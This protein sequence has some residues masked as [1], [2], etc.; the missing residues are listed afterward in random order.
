MTYTLGNASTSAIN[1]TSTSTGNTITTAGKALGNITFSGAGGSWQNQDDL[2]ATGGTIT[3]TAGEW[4]TGNRSITAVSF[5][6]ANSNVRTFTPGSSNLTFTGTSP[7]WTTSTHTNMTVTANTAT[8]TFTGTSPN[9]LFGSSRDWNGM[10]INL[11]GSG[12]PIINGAG[13]VFSSVTRTGTAVTTDGLFVSGDF[14]VTSGWTLA[15]NSQ[16]NR[17]LVTGNIAGTQRTI[18]NTGATMTWSNVDFEDIG[19]SSAYNAS[20]ITGGCG[21][22]GG[23]SN[24]TFTSP[25]TQTWSGTAS[26]SW[27]GNSWTSRMPLPQDNVVIASAFSPTGRV[28]TVDVPR[29]GASIDFTGT[30]GN[31]ALTFTS[32]ITSNIFGSLT[33]V[34]AMSVANINT[35]IQFAGRGS[36]TLTTAGQLIAPQIVLNA[37][38]GTLTMQDALTAGRNLTVT[39]GTLTTS[40]YA[41]AVQT[42]MALNSSALAYLNL[43]SSTVTLTGTGAIWNAQTNGTLNAG[44]STIVLTNTTAAAKSFTSS[45]TKSYSTVTMAGDNVTVNNTGTAS[46]GTLAVNTAGLPTGLK[47]TSGQTIPVGNVTSNGTAGNLAKLSSTTSGSAALLTSSSSQIAVDYM[48]IQDITAAGTATW[49]AGSHSTDVSGNTGWLWSD[50]SV[51]STIAIAGALTGS[52]SLSGAQVRRAILQAALAGNGSMVGTLRKRILIASNL[53]G[54]GTLSATPKRRVLISSNM[55]GTG[56]LS[57]T[58]T[59]RAILAANLAGIGSLSGTITRRALIGA[60]LTGTGSLTG[61]LFGAG[62]LTIP[63]A[64][65]LSGTGSMTATMVRRKLMQAALTGTSSMT[66][67]MVR[68]QPIT[69]ALTG[70]SGQTVTL[71]TRKQLAAALAGQGSLIGSLAGIQVIQRVRSFS[72]VIAGPRPVSNTITNTRPVSRD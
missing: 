69:G 57:G 5:S 44:T 60:N 38:G 17:L 27:S 42:A 19:L 28:V 34:S 51:G 37:P 9:L 30:T 11:P 65:A 26:G 16:T 49:Y 10:S 53:S 36:Y 39:M 8:V 66:G 46:I 54:S 21:D 1:F 68:R 33:L 56:S 18:T 35:V 52:G 24:I 48:S 31:P 3:L 43:I 40:G 22:C 7:A 67:S 64:G 55:T 2:T 61:A 14:A 4:D 59:R 23:N 50:P 32:G 58:V 12:S 41:V 72:P 63:I 25:S 47:L 45:G 71:V 20:A 29:M 6:S 62:G 70:T 13:C 15:G